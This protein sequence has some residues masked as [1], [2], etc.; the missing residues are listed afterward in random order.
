MHRFLAAARNVPLIV[1][2]CLLIIV[3]VA[4]AADRHVIAD[5]DGDGQHDNAT[6]DQQG[7]ASV[8]RV[9]LS[10]TRAV[11]TIGTATP[12]IGIA[13]RDLDGDHRDEL[14]GAGTTRLNVWTLLE[15]GFQR[16]Q[17]RKAGTGLVVPPNRRHTDEGAE[18]APDGIVSPTPPAAALTL[19]RHARPPT[20]ALH[21]S[22]STAASRPSTLLE[23][24]APRPPPLQR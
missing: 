11:A 24:S 8:I 9:W 22:H 17:P 21:A 20:R 1:C 2:A 6:L 14:V 10:S 12:I 13:A 15:S 16:V 5:F 4:A 18:G 23:S 7:L 19:S 3:Q